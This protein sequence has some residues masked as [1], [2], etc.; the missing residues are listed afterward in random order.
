MPD[1]IEQPRRFLAECLRVLRRPGVLYLDHPNGAFPIDFWH[2]DYRGRPRFHAPWEP[3]LPTY[4]EVVRLAHAADPDCQAEVL[5]PAGRFVYRR[6]ARRWYGKLLHAPLQLWFGLLRYWPFSRL[7]ASPLN[8][9]L[10]LRITPGPTTGSG[11]HTH[12]SAGS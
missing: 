2:C 3:F 9:Y 8:P 11:Y 5:S 7:A 4:R 12:A 1:Q 6:L 10:V